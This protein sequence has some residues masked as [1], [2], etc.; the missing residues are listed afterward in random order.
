MK[1][2]GFVQVQSRSGRAPGREAYGV[3]EKCR[4]ES[5]IAGGLCGD[6]TA[7]SPADTRTTRGSLL[8]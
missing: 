6:G 3:G 5:A 1:A 2:V 8:P 7:R 4:G